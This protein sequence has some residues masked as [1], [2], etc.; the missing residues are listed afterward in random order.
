MTA[1]ELIEQLQAVDPDEEVL[2]LTHY[3][4]AFLSMG[5]R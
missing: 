3:A 1:K 5:S 2:L 4:S